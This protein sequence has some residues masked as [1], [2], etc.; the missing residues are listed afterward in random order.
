MSAHGEA[1]VRFAP[2]PN[3]YLHLGHAYSALFSANLAARLGG[4]FLVRIEDIDMGRAREKFTDAIFEDLKWLGLTWPE[5]VRFQSKHFDAY[6]RAARRLAD[7]G[8]L[9]PCTCTR[10][11][12]AKSPGK[13]TAPD[14]GALYGGTCR[15][16]SADAKARTI[17]GAP[18]ALRLDMKKALARATGMAG[19]LTWRELGGDQ[20]T[21]KTVP[22]DPGAWGD[23]V[24][25]RKGVPTSYHLSVVVDDA[26]QNITHVTRGSD[27]Y[28]A[29]AIHRVLQVLLGLAEPN[30][31][32]HRLIVD[33]ERQK[34]AKSKGSTALRDL[35]AAGWTPAQ[36]RAELSV[37]K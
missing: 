11:Q 8:L 9:Y 32:H 33:H 13:R 15:L 16:N 22:A 36:V 7:L 37:R 34:L 21:E 28:A 26:V 31:A 5:P 20:L 23:I 10:A 2:S 4:K 1:I 29:T 12:L 14:G 18:F 25:V 3:G 19:P 35:R 27:L 24:V 6:G 17:S 30:Y